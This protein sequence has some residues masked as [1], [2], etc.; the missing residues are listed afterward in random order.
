MGSS[1]DER[2]AAYPC[3]DLI[4]CPDRVVFRAVGVRA[5]AELVFRWLCQLRV[6]PLRCK[7]LVLDPRRLSAIVDDR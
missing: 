2:A 5:L 1:T 6:A 3:D 4:D 7:Q